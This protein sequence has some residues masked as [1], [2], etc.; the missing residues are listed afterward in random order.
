[1]AKNLWGSLPN[2]EKLRTPHTVLQEQASLLAE[3]TG[4]LLLGQVH[5]D[6]AASSF[7]LTLRINAPALNN[8]SYTVL[9]V[10]HPIEL[11]PLHVDNET[12][13]SATKKCNT[14]EEFEQVLGSILASNEVQRVI[15]G[16]LA[17]IRADAKESLSENTQ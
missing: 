3:L 16:L 17:Q 6:Q 5:R 14:E 13:A 11:Y 10:S 9:K 2:V 15:A 7:K 1:M 12:R 4:G 8:Y